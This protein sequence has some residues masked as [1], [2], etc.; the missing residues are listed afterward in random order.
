MRSIDAIEFQGFFRSLRVL[1]F[2]K[3]TVSL[4]ETANRVLQYIISHW[5]FCYVLLSVCHGDLP[6]LYNPSMSKT[7][8]QIFYLLTF[9]MMERLWKSLLSRILHRSS[10]KQSF[11]LQRHFFSFSYK[12][13]EEKKKTLTL[14]MLE[15]EHVIKTFL[16][17]RL[18]FQLNCALGYSR[19]YP[20][21][22]KLFVPLS[23][24]IPFNNEVILMPRKLSA[25]HDEVAVAGNRVTVRTILL[26]YVKLIW[27]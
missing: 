6:K 8:A 21:L 13:Y 5:L 24:L 14:V 3:G 4:R 17:F 19:V 25:N 10:Y 1:T 22:W 2:L 23:W 9:N 12:D 16:F 26:G 11:H 15:R 20:M 27:G 7:R 18:H